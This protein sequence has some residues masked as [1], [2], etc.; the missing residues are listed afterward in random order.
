MADVIA[1][2]SRN[3]NVL[4]VSP[5][6]EAVFG[7]K[8]DDLH[9]RGLF[10]RVHVADRPAYLKALCDAATLRESR[11]VELRIRRDSIAP[12][13][14]GVFVWIELRCGPID[15]ATQEAVGEDSEGVAGSRDV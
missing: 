12:G 13:S 14:A 2:H 5:A 6:A 9:G 10:D 4:F 11:T 8:P 7:A 3:G 1:R 15:R